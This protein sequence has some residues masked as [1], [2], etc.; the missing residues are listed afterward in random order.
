MAYQ[1]ENSQS[2]AKAGVRQ[3]QPSHS[4][5]DTAAHFVRSNCLGFKNNAA[6]Q[7]KK[8]MS[9]VVNLSASSSSSNNTST[10]GVGFGC[11]IKTAK[12]KRKKNLSKKQKHK[13]AVRRW[14]ARRHQARFA[15]AKA[16][17]KA[18]QRK[19]SEKRH[20]R[21]T[22]NR[23]VKSPAYQA[24]C[25]E[26]NHASRISQ[27]PPPTAGGTTAERNSETVI[28]YARFTDGQGEFPSPRKRHRA[29][30][31]P[32]TRRQQ[33]LARREQ[34]RASGLLPV[35]AAMRRPEQL[36]ARAAMVLPDQHPVLEKARK[37]KRKAKRKLRSLRSS[38]VARPSDLV[39]AAEQLEK[40]AL[41]AARLAEAVKP[42]AKAAPK[43]AK[44]ATV[45]V[46][47][48]SKAALTSSDKKKEQ[49]KEEVT[50]QSSSR[51]EE[52]AAKC[53]RL[54]AKYYSSQGEEDY[55]AY[56]QALEDL[57]WLQTRPEVE[58]ASSEKNKEQRIE[59]SVQEEVVEDDFLARLDELRT[60]LEQLQSPVPQTIVPQEYY[61]KAA[62]KVAKYKAE[63]E[64]TGTDDLTMMLTLSL[65]KDQGGNE[66][67]VINFQDSWNGK[68][69]DRLLQAATKK[70]M[71]NLV[72]KTSLQK[73]EFTK[74]G[75]VHV[76]DEWY[77]L[78][79]E[80]N[81]PQNKEQPVRQ[82]IAPRAVNNAPKL[83][84]I[85]R[86]DGVDYLHLYPNKV[87]PK[88][89]KAL[90]AEPQKLDVIVNISP[91]HLGQ[92]DNRDK[93][94]EFLRAYGFE[95]YSTHTD[96]LKLPA[97]KPFAELDDNFLLNQEDESKKKEQSQESKKA[98][99]MIITVV[100]QA[101]TNTN[102][103]VGFFTVGD[104]TIQVEV[105]QDA[106]EAANR[107]LCVKQAIAYAVH[108]GAKAVSVE[109]NFGQYDL[110]KLASWKGNG[111][112]D[113]ANV[114][115]L[116]GIES[117]TQCL[118]VTWVNSKDKGVEAEAP[119][120]TAS[121]SPY[122]YEGYIGRVEA[123]QITITFGGK[124]ILDVLTT[125]GDEEDSYK[126]AEKLGLL[127]SLKSELSKALE[128]VTKEV[129]FLYDTH[130]PPVLYAVLE[131]LGFSDYDDESDSWMV[132]RVELPKAENK[133][134]EQENRNVLN[135]RPDVNPHFV[136]QARA[137]T[138]LPLPELLPQT[139]VGRISDVPKGCSHI[140]NFFTSE[141]KT[142]LSEVIVAAFSVMANEKGDIVPCNINTPSSAYTDDYVHYG[143]EDTLTT[144]KGENMNVLSLFANETKSLPQEKTPVV[145]SVGN[146]CINGVGEEFVP[147]AKSSFRRVEKRA[148]IQIVL[149]QP[150][151]E[152]A[153]TKEG[154]V[155]GVEDEARRG[156]RDALLAGDSKTIFSALFKDEKDEVGTETSVT[157]DYIGASL[158][159]IL[160]DC[161]RHTFVIVAWF[162]K[163]K[164]K[165]F[166]KG[167]KQYR[168]YPHT[169]SVFHVDD[170]T[171]VFGGTMFNFDVRSLLGLAAAPAVVPESATGSEVTREI[172]TATPPIEK[173][174][175]P[176]VPTEVQNSIA[177]TNLAK[178][179]ADLH[180]HTR[181]KGLR[182]SKGCSLDEV[183]RLR[184]NLSADALIA[185]RTLSY[186][187]S[188][189]DGKAVQLFDWTKADVLEVAKVFRSLMPSN[190][191]TADQQV[192]CY[193]EEQ[194]GLLL[195]FDAGTIEFLIGNDGRAYNYADGRAFEQGM[196]L[197]GYNE[198]NVSWWDSPEYDKVLAKFKQLGL[199]KALKN[200]EEEPY[201]VSAW[202]L[203][204]G[205]AQSRD[206]YTPV[207]TDVCF[208]SSIGKFM[209][210][211]CAY[212][213]MF[214]QS[215]N[216]TRGGLGDNF[217]M[218]LNKCQSVL[219]MTEGDILGQ[220]GGFLYSV[221][222]SP[223]LYVHREQ[224]D[225]YALPD[226]L[227]AELAS[228]VA[229]VVRGY[230]EKP[231]KEMLST[232]SI[233]TQSLAMEVAFK[234]YPALG[235]HFSKGTFINGLTH[236]RL[237]TLQQ[238]APNLFKNVLLQT[239]LDVEAAVGCVVSLTL[240]P[241]KGAKRATLALAR[242]VE[243]E[244]EV[245]AGWAFYGQEKVLKGW[246]V[247]ECMAPTFVMAPGMSFFFGNEDEKPV[248][249]VRKTQ[250]EKYS[251]FL[252]SNLEE[253]VSM[254]GVTEHMKCLADYEPT[255]TYDEA[256]ATYRITFD[257]EVK[258]LRGTQ[259]AFVK[260][261]AGRGADAVITFNQ[262]DIAIL[263][264][265]SWTVHK[266]LVGKQVLVV[267][268]SYTLRHRNP[269]L[270]GVIKTMM[271]SC[272][273]ELLYN[274][275][276]EQKLADL[277]LNDIKLV[278]PQDTIKSDMLYSWL[279]VIGNTIRYNDP[280]NPHIAKLMR[281]RDK[282]NQEMMGEAEYDRDTIVINLAAVLAG[283]YSELISYFVRHFG[284]SLWMHVQQ[285]G[286]Q[287]EIM[288]RLYDD[289]VMN[290]A[291]W[292]NVPEEA[293]GEQEKAWAVSKREEGLSVKLYA[294][295][296]DYLNND[297]Q[298]ALLFALDSDEVVVE[299][300]QRSFCFVGAEGAPVYGVELF[301]SSTVAE[302]ISDSRHM[303]PSV[304]SLS[305]ME[306][307]AF[308]D[309][310]ALLNAGKPKMFMSLVIAGM[311]SCDKFNC[312]KTV[313]ILEQGAN[314]EK[315]LILSEEDKV[316][317]NSILAEKSINLDYY[318]ED[319][320]KAV[321]H[322][323]RDIVF[324]A[325]GN[326][327]WLPGLFA[328][329][330]LKSESSSNNLAQQFFR[331]ILVECLAGRPVPAIES[332]R[333]AGI[334]ESLCESSTK[335]ITAAG[336]MTAK[337][338]ALPHIPAGEIHILKSTHPASNY[339][340]LLRHGFD[341]KGVEA[342]KSTIFTHNSRAPLT[343]GSLLKLVVVT[344]EKNSENFWK[345]DSD[346]FA[347]GS[348]G[349]GM[350]FGDFDGDGHYFVQLVGTD[351]KV[352]TFDSVADF[353]SDAVGYYIFNTYADPL[354]G[355][356]E[357]K[358]KNE[359]Y[360]A[361][362]YNIKKWSKVD[363]TLCNMAVKKA[364]KSSATYLMYNQ[365]AREM[366]AKATGIAYS[367]Y[368]W[369]EHLVDILL[370]YKKLGGVLPLG[371][372]AAADGSLVAPISQVYEVILGGFS[373]PA[374]EV[375]TKYFLKM[376]EGEQTVFYHNLDEFNQDLMAMGITGQ[377]KAGFSA[378]MFA[379]YHLFFLEK[380]GA[381]NDYVAGTTTKNPLPLEL[382]GMLACAL[383]SFEL[384][385]GKFQGFTGALAVDKGGKVKGHTE[386]MN[387]ARTFLR[388]TP[389]MINESLVCKQLAQAI[390]VC[391]HLLAGKPR[392]E[393]NLN[394]PVNLQERT[395]DVP[396]SKLSEEALQ[397]FLT[398]VG[399]Q[400]EVETDD[401]DNEGGSEVAVEP[402]TPNNGDGGAAV[403]AVYYAACP[404]TEEKP[405]QLVAVNANDVAVVAEHS[406]SEQEGVEVLELLGEQKDYISLGGAEEERALGDF[407]PELED[408]D[409]LG[410]VELVPEPINN[411]ALE[412]VKSEEQHKA[413]LVYYLKANG[414]K[415]TPVELSLQ[416]KLEKL[417][418][419]REVKVLEEFLSRLDID[420]ETD[421]FAQED[422]D[423]E[424][425]AVQLAAHLANEAECYTDGNIADFAKTVLDS[426]DPPVAAV[427]PP[428]EFVEFVE[429]V[430]SKAFEK[431]V[432]LTAEQKERE[433]AYSLSTPP[434]VV[435]ERVELP[436][437]Q[438]QQPVQSEVTEI[439]AKE[440]RATLM[441]VAEQL[442]ESAL[443]KLLAEAERLLAEL[444]KAQTPVQNAVKVTAL[445][446]P[447]TTLDNKSLVEVVNKRD[448][449]GD[450]S[451]DRGSFIGNPFD[452]PDKGNAKQ[453]AE[454]INYFESF[455]N[456]VVYSGKEPAVAIASGV[457][458]GATLA[459]TWKEPS[460]KAF[461]N[462]LLAIWDVVEAKG[463][464]EVSCWC[465]P[466]PCHLDVVKAD[467]EKAGSKA[468]WLAG[469][470][471][472]KEVEEVEECPDV[473]KPKDTPK[474]S[475]VVSSKGKKPTNSSLE[476]T[477]SRGAVE[478]VKP[479]VVKAH[480]LDG[481]PPLNAST[482]KH[483]VKDIAMAAVA[484]QFIGTSAV[485][486]PSST[487]LYRKAW[488]DWKGGCANTG[489]YTA[490][491][492]V[493][494][495]G[496]S[497]YRATDAAY[498][499]Y[500]FTKSYVPYLVLV[501]NA[502]ATVVVGDCSGIDSLVKAY[503]VEAGYQKTW[504]A[505][506]VGGYN[507]LTPPSKPSKPKR[508]LL[509]VNQPAQRAEATVIQPKGNWVD[510]LVSKLE[511]WTANKVK[512]ALAT[513]SSEQREAAR[514]IIQHA[515][516]NT[517]A[518]V[519]E[520]DPKD[521]VGGHILT[522]KAGTGKSYTADVIIKVLDLLGFRVVACGTTGLAS[523][524]LD[525]S[526][527]TINR[528]LNLLDGFERKKD[529]NGRLLPL[530]KGDISAIVTRMVKGG[531]VAK[532][533][534]EQTDSK[535]YVGVV[536]LVDEA[537]MLGGHLAIAAAAGI[538]AITAAEAQKGVVRK[539]P[540]Q[541]LLVGDPKQ[542]EPVKDVL[543][544]EETQ[545]LD[546]VG[547]EKPVAHPSFTDHM[548]LKTIKLLKNERQSGDS[549]FAEELDLLGE[550]KAAPDLNN[551]PVI[552]SRFKESLTNQP[553]DALHII[554]N[555]EETALFNKQK[556]EELIQKTGA[557]KQVYKAVI[558]KGSYESVEKLLSDISPT[559]E[560]LELVEGVP[561]RVTQNVPKNDGTDDNKV[562]NG[563][564]GRVIHL[565]KDKVTVKFND[566]RVE[567]LEA[568]DLDKKL[569]KDENGAPM[570]EFKQIPLCLCW[571][572]TFHGSQGQTYPKGEPVIVHMYSR[573]DPRNPQ[574]VIRP[575][576]VNNAFYVA[577]S[578]VTRSED[579][580]FY[581]GLG[582]DEKPE[583]LTDEEFVD[584]RRNTYL[585]RFKASYKF[586]KAALAWL[587]Q[588]SC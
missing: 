358:N 62:E 451:G 311:S 532:R 12:K 274:Q 138:S 385:R 375:Y 324:V 54:K 360:L 450:I 149:G 462:S 68:Q 264:E 38:P 312:S 150:G 216:N 227:V 124:N 478:E 255:R 185:H 219:S 284:H 526:S 492:V 203:V 67:N 370:A 201:T 425:F 351:Y 143:L 267:N 352:S 488:A 543:L 16:S 572:T 211:F 466:L 141:A 553:A 277:G 409:L 348:M 105:D 152:S 210:A 79:L 365:N 282:L 280:T 44:K 248:A 33:Q 439:Q 21:Q 472:V 265:I 29:F 303:P 43:A 362:H 263:N 485:Y 85:R 133:V 256:S 411:M 257:R 465:A 231:S 528:V 260:K 364:T 61:D 540:V 35:T 52:T 131:K 157:V 172:L 500:H 407:N 491:D 233:E 459:R 281:L 253:A 564:R 175:E 429:F 555:K 366:Q 390:E 440:K 88:S 146:H 307:V 308:D 469:I 123:S 463:L 165:Y 527:G 292:V 93:F 332:S 377:K 251:N 168:I 71:V 209:Q 87:T 575:V 512:Q 515:L 270:R 577:C 422:T 318:E 140:F 546:R 9:K 341:L 75:F 41:R 487:E 187:K 340:N 198:H 477:K 571:A 513:L 334:L 15:I 158:E 70:V 396:P 561:V 357:E 373:D 3:N 399:A 496:N 144:K 342:G 102:H 325:K 212:L 25:R 109:Y 285:P 96:W 80:D 355:F 374:W 484:T 431:P 275:F 191:A 162:D 448:K 296:V 147:T 333:A 454:V 401:S 128:G 346:T 338:I 299:Y 467:F 98:E 195:S 343:D 443:E 412:Y 508:E 529:A 269:K 552:N 328:I 110:N 155:P 55:I 188:R 287:G 406:E 519:A 186:I 426:I 514:I 97:G 421:D 433:G 104:T 103:A 392:A 445:R 489:V 148:N 1:Q 518:K 176:A 569:S 32:I 217:K 226:D 245:K 457:I 266:D 536:L 582:V 386:A 89:L 516:D 319:Q 379:S 410:L 171:A 475:L 297:K 250:T 27:T 458:A 249:I 316:Y 321:A 117:L 337:R 331:E 315:N 391:D 587:E 344:E 371:F 387:H 200:I 310:W 474:V 72:G 273:K 261:E 182:L 420:T 490:K 369:S 142:G 389:G 291:G 384:M 84:K 427:E 531:K 524:N 538:K 525:G 354:N 372:D 145:L 238:H 189:T 51:F 40:A 192:F 177:T 449:A 498:L 447:V 361:D 252:A 349:N 91:E 395:I 418:L 507:R 580:F 300:L 339:Q 244:G 111:F 64:A 214:A 151:G 199:E 230:S 13:Q 63:A 179:L 505:A 461:I 521:V 121:F 18:Q 408:L 271:G 588:Q 460:R 122:S 368:M 517:T 220:N 224:C 381:F 207:I 222:N 181:L 14:K 2:F 441:K 228:S 436:A 100:S 48:V 107:L 456:S 578:R 221:Q 197:I 483:M 424:E 166:T 566:G 535:T 7:R 159:S 327:Y 240:K 10:A 544:C 563:E 39:K 298:N 108:A 404:T 551:C 234:K 229:S 213:L 503:L 415:A 336:N 452:L 476:E 584:Y 237:A 317:L 49:R 60:Q 435:Q 473:P 56:C 20:A 414:Y 58:T 42:K 19:A 132:R 65:R 585:G 579:L 326:S 558:S 137:K 304:R 576:P 562:A 243:V 479:E 190:K 428:V 276:N 482:A 583:H 242:G 453:R 523:Q 565:S 446:E 547:D 442:P 557:V 530:T 76:A 36:K 468:A 522:G 323:F 444:N 286:D 272:N 208:S 120:V 363:E 78:S 506:D 66:V 225:I 258:L 183:K 322:A 405:L 23:W 394:D 330:K 81:K 153:R 174:E 26:A 534:S 398:K 402:N 586:N 241:S 471:Q 215:K 53:E 283:L 541:L 8:L 114:A 290:N 301:E 184:P 314:K 11:F 510:A 246:L 545:F 376:S 50:S 239:G 24:L 388:Q 378:L 537:F 470:H 356:K 502:K 495:S 31:R 359:A 205:Q 437:E 116:K 542:F 37:E 559:P 306:G 430:N 501:V 520:L 223:K 30:V 235:F 556:L 549:A 232:K 156:L 570:G 34:L 413:C 268:Y 419:D 17:R 455:Y 573:Q 417:L 170:M 279:M 194:E 397:Y 494:V 112:K 400:A 4:V 57:Q 423:T 164:H 320:F 127:D 486:T 416:E 493:M 28:K 309:A 581:T 218:L 169:A 289:K 22:K 302:A 305:R 154:A 82:P 548:N 173:T 5:V 550:G 295:S 350:D 90:L 77:C 130:C 95:N 480:P 125:T 403:E 163:D 59:T 202:Y 288:N 6:K 101:K 74:R 99:P 380:W 134:V 94:V 47:K 86:G 136:P 129:H 539:R 434:A 135:R 481:L 313:A 393:R 180:K 259:I 554:F 345:L 432:E 115:L 247:Q 46:A 382:K 73:S 45:K 367:V 119:R 499:E 193:R 160:A 204:N 236:V 293:W 206:I 438:T 161:R 118:S 329:N 335:L 178:E 574:S 509:N 568:V 262:N 278:S 254:T 83:V 383:V 533:L 167:G 511:S 347:L 497:S 196:E 106:T 294:E 464:A 69:I 92:V 139:E 113:K 126:Q 353:I 567:E 560:F 504:V